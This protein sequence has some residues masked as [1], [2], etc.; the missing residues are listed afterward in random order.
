MPGG[1]HCE[2]YSSQL[3]Y[4]H[5]IIGLTL[6]LNMLKFSAVGLLT[7]SLRP[8]TPPYKYVTFSQ[9]LY[10]T[11]EVTNSNSFRT[12]RERKQLRGIYGR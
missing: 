6:R 3:I 7:V 8:C 12:R 9:R 10:I 5:F 1:L 11:Y 2:M 4:G